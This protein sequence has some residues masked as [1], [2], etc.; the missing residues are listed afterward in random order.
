MQR[1]GYLAKRPATYPALVVVMD[2]PGRCRAPERA[3]RSRE[4]SSG[5]RDPEGYQNDDPS[6]SDRVVLAD[7]PADEIPAPDLEDLIDRSDRGRVL[8]DR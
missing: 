7:E 4:G 3:L 1:I 6:R 2:Q 8:R 5:Q